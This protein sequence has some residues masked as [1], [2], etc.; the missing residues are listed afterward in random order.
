M[1]FDCCLCCSSSPP[2]M[3]R[4]TVLSVLWLHLTD[5][6]C[7]KMSY[8]A[9]ITQYTEQIKKIQSESFYK[10]IKEK[11]LVVIYNVSTIIL[12][13]IMLIHDCIFD[14]FS[15]FKLFL[16]LE[17][18]LRD[19]IHKFYESKY[20]S[21]LKLLGEIKVSLFHCSLFVKSA[22]LTVCWFCKPINFHEVENF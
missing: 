14:F 1:T 6:N 2:V 8:L 15:S 17:P 21:C 5:R 11:C 12:T 22:L 20:A 3:W 9:G 7:R 10:S 19:I 18:Q 4:H 16:E 13:L